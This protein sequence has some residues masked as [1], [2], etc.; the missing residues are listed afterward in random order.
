MKK[1]S[2]STKRINKAMRR[3]IA[4][5]EANAEVELNRTLLHCHEEYHFIPTSEKRKMKKAN[6]MDESLIHILANFGVKN[7]PN[8]INSLNEWKKN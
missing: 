4:K 3:I 1:E 5:L 8:F 7:E 2:I 6:T